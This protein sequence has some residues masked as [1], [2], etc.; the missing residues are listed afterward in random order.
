MRFALKQPGFEVVLK[1]LN[2]AANGTVSYE[3]FVSGF[4]QTTVPRG[5]FE[6]AQGIEWWQSSPH[7]TF[8]YL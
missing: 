2:V 4:G 1:L 7:L 6:R 5:G 3:K 8:Q